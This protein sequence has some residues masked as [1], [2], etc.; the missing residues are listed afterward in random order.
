[1]KALFAIALLL[2]SALVQA[3]ESYFPPPQNNGWETISPADLGW[4]S[5]ALDELLAWLDEKDTKAFIVLKDG[6]IAV[7]AY[8]G[9]FHRNRQW[10][11]ASA[12]KTVTAFLIGLLEKQGLLNLEDAVSQHLG[13]G[14]TSFPGQREDLITVRDQL[15]MTTGLEYQVADQG[16]TLPACL[17]YRSDAGEQWYYHNAPYTLLTHVIE[18]A[19]GRDLNAFL[20]DASSA[21]P[22]FNAAYVDGLLS[23]FNRTVFSRALDMARFGLFISQG[24]AW[25]NRA[26]PLSTAYFQAMVTP[27]QS[28]NP[29]YGFLWW[30]NGQASFIPPAFATPLPGPLADTAPADMFSAIGHNGQFLSIVPSENLVVVRLGDNPGPLFQFNAEKWQRLERAMGQAHAQQWVTEPVSAPGVQ[31]Q[32]FDS[33]AVGGEVS[34]H[35]FLPAAYAAEPERRFPV[36]YW[37]HGSNGVLGGIDELSR[38]FAQA[39]EDGHL[40]PLIVVFPNGLPYGMWVDAASGEQPVERLLMFDLVQQVDATFRSIPSPAGRLIDGFSMGGYGAARLGLR[41]WRCFAGF[42]MNGAGPLQLDFLE[43][44][45]DFAPLALRQQLLKQ[46]YGNDPAFFAAQSPL[47]LAAVHGPRLPAHYPIRQIIGTEDSML[48]TNRAFRDHLNALGIAHEFIELDG[49]EHNMIQIMNSMGPDFWR[50][51]REA[52]A[53]AEGRMA[54]GGTA[55]QGCLARPITEVRGA[56]SGSWFDP[57]RNGEGFVF[58]FGRNPT[59]PVVTVFWFTHLTDEPYWLYGSV[60]YDASQFDQIGWLE[61]DLLEVSGTGF[62]TAFDAGAIAQFERGTLKVVFDGCNQ[63]SALWTPPEGADLLGRETL[64]YQ[65]QRITLG[66][67]GAQCE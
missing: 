19:S 13:I 33:A 34:F 60:E 35:V 37:L 23:D 40:P 16:C 5:N 58:E 4:D 46:V 14:W 59:A 1:M 42:S 62:G 53:A 2:S 49:V 54:D 8:F 15:S 28:L 18:S 30:L 9:D 6:K 43:D 10:Y 25:G 11:W 29:S 36:L 65:L 24:A 61:L 12:G 66:L 48:R 38:R 17:I 3:T 22:G 63:A 21:I 39:I 45:T 7:E 55:A 31:Y 20:G 26:S 27:S 57:S 47:R 41:Y 51:Y 67:D 52:L 44:S 32:Q 50:F 56:L 64:A